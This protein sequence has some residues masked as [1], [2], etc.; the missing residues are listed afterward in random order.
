MN[1]IINERA[2]LHRLIMN[3]INYF[4]G[5]LRGEVYLPG[6]ISN[7]DVWIAWKFVQCVMRMLKLNGILSLLAI[8]QLVFGRKEDC[9]MRSD[10]P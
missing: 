3:V 9:F 6:V 2:Y 4:C 1:V 7:E 10:Q 8:E 5:D